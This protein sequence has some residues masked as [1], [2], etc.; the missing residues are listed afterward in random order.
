MCQR[1][2]VPTRFGASV[3][4]KAYAARIWAWLTSLRVIEGS[5]DSRALSMLKTCGGFVSNTDR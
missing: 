1:D 3:V 5:R 4:D 2:D